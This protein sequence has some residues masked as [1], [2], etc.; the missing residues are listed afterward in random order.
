MSSF[1]FKMREEINQSMESD[2][3]DL[4]DQLNY[5]YCDSTSWVEDV[6][7]F[8][9]AL[10][11]K[12][13]EQKESIRRLQF[14][15]H[16]GLLADEMAM[17]LIPEELPLQPEE[18]LVAVKTTLNGDCLFNTVSLVMDGTESNTSLLHH[19][20]GTLIEHGLLHS[21]SKTYLVFQH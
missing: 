4:F 13:A 10:D 6:L 12:Y 11:E 3:S 20:T 15:G 19:G 7:V 5:M 18:H 1:E 2:R 17:V 9:H 14:S 21:T 16:V 8:A